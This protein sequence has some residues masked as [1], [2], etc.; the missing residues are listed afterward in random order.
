MV[1]TSVDPATGVFGGIYCSK[2]GDAEKWY[3]LTGRQ[4]TDGETVGWTVNW[5]NASNNSHS[6]TTWSGQQ[7]LRD[8]DSL[9]LTTWLLTSQTSPENDWESTQIGFDQFSLNDPSSEEKEKAKF[10]C[11]KSHPK[12][13]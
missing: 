6:V 5:N 1:I 4:D 12:D 8:G 10:H 11:R 7:R 2:V 13:A 9:I 3:V